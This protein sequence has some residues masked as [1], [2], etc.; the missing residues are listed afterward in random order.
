[1]H[2]EAVLENMRLELIDPNNIT[3]QRLISR[4][5]PNFLTSTCLEPPMASANTERLLRTLFWT[6]LTLTVAF[7]VYG[8]AV[9]FFVVGL[10][11]GE[12]GPVRILSSV[13][14]AG[15]TL[16]CAFI[17]RSRL[18]RRLPAIAALLLWLFY[19][20]LPRY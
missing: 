1:M 7:T 6:M 15:L 18:P 3:D 12:A 10:F 14:A 8:L 13:T 4:A 19:I 20:G 16:V 11:S 17:A 9:E 2:T 5:D